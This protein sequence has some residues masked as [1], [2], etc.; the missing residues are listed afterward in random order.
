MPVLI[1]G[2]LDMNKYFLVF[3][4]LILMTSIFGNVVENGLKQ[5]SLNDRVCMKAFFEEAII[6]DQAAHVIFFKSKPVCFTGPA[7]KHCDKSFR[8][9]LVLRGWQAFKR[10]ENLFPHPNFIFSEC[11]R[12]S[13]SDYKM[14]DIYIIN[15][16]ALI[17]CVLNNNDLFKAALGKDF[18]PQKFVAKLEEGHPLPALIHDNEMLLGILLGYGVESSKAFA[19]I[20]AHHN[21]LFAPPSTDFYQRIDLKQPKGCKIQPVV[22]MGNPQSTEVKALMTTYEVE[23]E[24]ISKTYGKKKGLLKVVLEKLCE[25]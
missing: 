4:P 13:D 3:L 12:E 7:L 2:S 21:G 8:D 18:D 1:V 17:K 22:F 11:I 9:V 23:L 14:L 25:E 19:E 16:Q 24:E 20:M 6:K 5:I 15:K 10:H